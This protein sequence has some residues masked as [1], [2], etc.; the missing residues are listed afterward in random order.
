[1]K[2]ALAAAAGAWLL[3][4]APAV[5]A[6]E[7]A[8]DIRACL[9]N[10]LPKHTRVQTIE[11]LAVDRSGGRRSMRVSLHW[12]RGDDDLHRIRLRIEQPTDL[13]G[14]SYLVIEKTGE[15]EMFVYLPATQRVRRVTTAMISGSLWGTDFSYADVKQMQG[16]ALNGDVR[17][18]EDTTFAD[19]PVY[20]LE[21]TGAATPDS[22]YSKIVSF[23]DRDTC[24]ALQTAF[25]EHG[26]EVRKLLTADPGRIVRENDRWSAHDL[27]MRDLENGTATR[28]HVLESRSDVDV[29]DRLFTPSMLGRAR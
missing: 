14:S 21:A 5:H 17:R 23:V 28:M 29:P 25:Y 18:L 19:R 22:V 13:R 4:L 1:M 10:N 9:R 2:H 27:E 24:V 6:L 7:T 26:D 16:I 8:E 20:V 15:D 12:K 3:L 11:L